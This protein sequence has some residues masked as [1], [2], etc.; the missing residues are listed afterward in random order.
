[1]LSLQKE[2]AD[3][4]KIAYQNAPLDVASFHRHYKSCAMGE[5][6]GMCC[7]G[8]SGF[9][10][11][12][13]ADTIQTL[14]DENR[15]F[16]DA[17][18]LPMPPALFEYY[19][20]AI[21]DRQM[22]TLET[23]KMK[24]PEGLLPKHFPETSCIFKRQDGACSLQLLSIEKGKPGWWYKPFAC[25]AFPL[26]L[27]DDNGPVIRVAHKSTDTDIDENYA[28]FVD[29]TKCGKECA[30]G[31]GRPAYEVLKHEIETFSKIVER[32]IMK[33]IMA[34]KEAA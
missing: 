3:Q 4:W 22:A 29:F 15:A 7:N 18:G 34:Y 33:E 12:K 10:V 26:E 5:C 31:E 24:H 25:W 13:E 32:D 28:G 8:G 27:E 23:R 11:D 21:Q 17:Q 20:D 16:F 19:H 1:M 9:F 2:F 6:S 30:K 14:V